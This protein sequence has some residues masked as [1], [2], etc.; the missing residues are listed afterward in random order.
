MCLKP[1]PFTV[2]FSGSVGGK[3]MTLS[4]TRKNGY[5]KF[6]GSIGVNSF[7]SKGPK[8]VFGTSITVTHGEATEGYSITAMG[9][10]V[11]CV[12]ITNNS[13]DTKFNIFGWTL[14]GGVGYGGSIGG[15]RTRF[16]G[17]IFVGRAGIPV[18]P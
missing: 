18:N 3:N 2:T 9:C 11:L 17:Q 1:G 12:G 16:M 8:G 5:L 4:I 15:Q 10:R 6:Y 14:T 13:T 7:S